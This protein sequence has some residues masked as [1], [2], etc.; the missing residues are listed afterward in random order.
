MR[1]NELVKK[2]L[3]AVLSVIAMPVAMV[4]VMVLFGEPLE[5]QMIGFFLGA[6]LIGVVLSRCLIHLIFRSRWN[7]S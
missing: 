1:L 3:Q 7:S 4:G 5:Y 6:A 2:L